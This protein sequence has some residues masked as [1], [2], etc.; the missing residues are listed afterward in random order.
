MKSDDET[1][2]N[3]KDRCPLCGHNILLNRDA[4][5]LSEMLPRCPE[6]G[7]PE[8]YMRPLEESDDE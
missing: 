1:R 3:L 4:L 5:R 8:E 2:F 7:R 6:C